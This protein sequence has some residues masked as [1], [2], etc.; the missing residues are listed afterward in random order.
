MP[1]FPEFQPGYLE[2]ISSSTVFR[3][4]ARS[5]GRQNSSPGT[6]DNNTRPSYNL[7][8]GKNNDP[9]YSMPPDTGPCCAEVRSVRFELPHQNRHH[10]SRKST[11]QFPSAGSTTF[12]GDR[13][14]EPPDTVF[15]KCCRSVRCRSSITAQQVSGMEGGNLFGVPI[16]QVDGG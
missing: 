8:P 10:S 6:S 16:F 1:F 4:T 9:G 2:I 3:P 11:P 13:M 7:S 15:S 5:R 12:S 14:E